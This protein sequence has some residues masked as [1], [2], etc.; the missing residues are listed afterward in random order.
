MAI[1]ADA[2]TAEET[3]RLVKVKARHDIDTVY[4]ISNDGLDIY[5]GKDANDLIND[6]EAPETDRSYYRFFN[7]ERQK[8]VYISVKTSETTLGPLTFPGPEKYGTTSSELYAKAV[9]YPTILAQC[10]ELITKRKPTLWE[11]IMK[12]TTIITAIVVVIFILFI[13]AVGMTG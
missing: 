11:R 8:W 4:S 5:L 7:A 9:T 10:I 12:P 13:M 2:L 3:G 1:G 6:I